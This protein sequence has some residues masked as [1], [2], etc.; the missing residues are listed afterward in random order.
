MQRSF[1]FLV[2]AAVLAVTLPLMAAI[3]QPVST[4][5]GPVAGAAVAGGT[6]AAF[7]G[8][9]FAAPPVGDLRWRAPQPPA[10]WTAVRKAEQ[11]S[12]SCVQNIVEERKPWT[13]EYMAHNRI[14]ED[15]LYLNVWTPA[16]TAGDKLPVYFW[17]YGGGYVEGSTAVPVYDGENLARRGVVIVTVNYRLGVLG[18]LAH[19]ELT[20]E[21][22]HSG[23]Y[24]SLDQLAALQWVQKN[25]AAFG[26]DPG[27]V[28]IA[29]QSAGSS[30]VH[31][32]VASP[33][34]KGLFQRAIAE[35]GS[36]YVAANAGSTLADAEKAGVKFATAKGAANLKELRAK[37]PEALLAQ[38]SD[39][40][41][42]AFRP[43]VDGY[44]LPAEPNEI[45]AQGRQNDVPELT[46][47]NRDERSSEA[48]YGA[49]PMAMYQKTMQ[50]RYGDLAGTFFKL[51]PNS[52]QEQSG[53]TQ[54][55]VYRDAG[56]VSMYM[57]GQ[58]REKTA[59]SK[60]FT[61]YWTHAETG[62]DSARF[63]AHHTSEVPYVFNTL[64]QSK[65]P[66]TDEDHK[67]SDMLGSYW[68]N[69]MKSGD[70][71]GPGLPVW[72]AFSGKSADTMELGD[73]SG[74]RPVADAAKVE[75]WEKYLMRPQAVVR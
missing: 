48:D 44:F 38:L 51:Y 28:T 74:S 50:D 3:P 58:L 18:F 66:W 52:T 53:N 69:F 1:R 46:G 72:P 68:V 12:A 57:W 30:G 71:N 64:N 24:G 49:R 32:L 29:G 54:K 16:K 8:I 39:G 14:S 45:Y 2:G 65:R 40:S 41:S 62:P 56:L 75:F 55:A 34:A 70:P 59:K 21:A 60:S 9:P 19:P 6:V 10:S 20:K 61:Y 67:L 42:S 43:V 11:F 27:N 4:A 22:G 7:K 31:N 15:C 13:Y 47:M 73:K 5:N 35:S 36:G 25:I 23:N 33:L 26:G 63:G 17:I 37:S